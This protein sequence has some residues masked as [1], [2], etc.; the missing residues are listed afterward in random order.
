MDTITITETGCYLDSHRGHYITRDAI[1]IAQGYGF[2]VG[3]FAQWAIDT[4]EE[5]AYLAADPKE[6]PHESLIELCD[7]AV[8]WLNSGQQDCDNCGGT[9]TSNP[10]LDPNA[11]RDIH[12]IWRCKKCT[13]TGRGPRIAGQNFPPKVPEGYSWSFNDGDF[14]L[15]SDNDHD[16]YI[17]DAKRE[18]VAR[19]FGPNGEV[20]YPLGMAVK[21]KQPNGDTKIHSIVAIGRDS[22]D[23]VWIKLDE[24]E[25][26]FD[27][28][29][30]IIPA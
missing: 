10:A 15:Y 5:M 22:D 19:A 30:I 9:G 7:E 4:Y 11:W 6:Y 3:P 18:E 17:M 14:G 8:N 21:F 23:D 1:Q 16:E 26:F 25:P 20:A 24:G 28:P 29:D 2:I 13:G 12:G 27:W